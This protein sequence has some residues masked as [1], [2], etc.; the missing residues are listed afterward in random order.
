MSQIDHLRGSAD[1]IRRMEDVG[2]FVESIDWSIEE[3]DLFELSG[4]ARFALGIEKLLARRENIINEEFEEW[5]FQ[6]LMIE[7][8]VFEFCVRIESLKFQLSLMLNPSKLR[9]AR[10]EQDNESIVLRNLMLGNILERIKFKIYPL[11][12]LEGEAKQRQIEN[13]NAV[14]DLFFL[15]FR[16]AIIHRNFE[17][18][19]NGLAYGN[20]RIHVGAEVFRQ[21][22]RNL[23]TLELTIEE[24]RNQLDTR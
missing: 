14:D 2:L 20:L 8:R 22:S 23:D 3:G 24:K 17:Q 1:L 10:E 12:S 21:M 18:V 9:Y 13:R 16:N 5:E 6:S 19:P 4:H 7:I 15:D 11:G